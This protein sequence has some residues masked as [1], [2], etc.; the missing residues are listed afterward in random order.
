MNAYAKSADTYLA[1]R[2]QNASPEQLAA[3]IMEAGVIH[4]GKAIRALN[5]RDL[6]AANSSYLRISECI[7][8]ATVLLDL[9]G[10]GEVARNLKELYD[11][12]NA[13]L[14]LASKHNDVARLETILNGMN[15]IRQAWEQLHET[16]A[17]TA[18]QPSFQAGD[19]IV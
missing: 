1:Q 18:G 16:K 6:T 7:M 2:I 10:G 4:V 19:Q 17:G 14:L 9:E 13:Q 8:E 3:L 12:W 5:N 11:W 15:E